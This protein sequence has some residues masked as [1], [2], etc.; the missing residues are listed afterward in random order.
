LQ[1][2]TKPERPLSESVEWAN[3]QLRFGIK[4]LKGLVCSQSFDRAVSDAVSLRWTLANH[5]FWWQ[6]KRL[7]NWLNLARKR[8]NFLTERREN[9]FTPDRATHCQEAGG[10]VLSS[11]FDLLSNEALEAA[12]DEYVEDCLK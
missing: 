6:A 9:T 10:D 2:R 3:S 1:S 11:D 12:I 7:D 5:G 8:G 4:L